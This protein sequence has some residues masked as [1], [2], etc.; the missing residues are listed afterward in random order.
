MKKRIIALFLSLLTDKCERTRTAYRAFIRLR[1]PGKKAQQGGF[2]GAVFAD[3]AY[4]FTV[5]Y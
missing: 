3:E 2:S 4:F 1:F 5:I